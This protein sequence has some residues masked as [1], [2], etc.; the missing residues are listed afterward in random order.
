MNIKKLAASLMMLS[1]CTVGVENISAASAAHVPEVLN[2]VAGIELGNDPAR[3]GIRI[4]VYRD[5]GEPVLTAHSREEGLFIALL[6]KGINLL[7]PEESA[8]FRYIGVDSFKKFMQYAVRVGIN[9]ASINGETKM[10]ARSTL[11]GAKEAMMALAAAD[12]TLKK[13]HVREGIQASTDYISN[14]TRIVDFAIRISGA[15]SVTAFQGALGELGNL[16]IQS[17]DHIISAHFS[18][19]GVKGDTGRT[20]DAHRKAVVSLKI[21]IAGLINWGINNVINAE[22]QVQH[23]KEEYENKKMALLHM[24]LIYLKECGLI[25]SAED[26]N[27][28]F[29]ALDPQS[30]ANGDRPLWDR[31]EEWANRNNTLHMKT[32]GQETH[33]QFE[34]RC[35]ASGKVPYPVF[36]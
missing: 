24:S 4:P 2:M 18:S 16:S 22:Q 5:T 19:D 23:T 29:G 35:R 9:A 3:P 7:E 12:K 10:G 20:F 6:N 28:N 15:M 21:M 11:K 30:A 13:Q 36:D 26:V 34:A 1:L 32:D 14:I 8:F 27:D 33:N 31:Y 17:L 25:Q